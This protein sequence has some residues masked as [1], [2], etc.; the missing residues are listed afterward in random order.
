MK[1]ITLLFLA[2]FFLF[3]QTRIAIVG[4]GMAGVSALYHLQEYDKEAKITLFEKEAVLGGNATTVAIK[5]TKGEICTVDAGP[6]Y[7]A[8][9][10]WEDYLDFIEK[11]IGKEEIKYE[12]VGG[13][14]VIRQVYE[15]NAIIATPLNGK[16][17]GEKLG[18][19]LKF[20]KLNEEAHRLYKEA[21][22]HSGL[23]IE[24]WV[25]SLNFDEDYKQQIVYPFLGSS[26][27]VSVHDIRKMSAVDIV[28]LF[29]FRKPK[30]SDK[31]HIMQ[32]GMGTII[33]KI[34]ASVKNPNV[35]IHTSALVHDVLLKENTYLVTY[36]KNGKSVTEEF[37]F[38][39]M[40]VH[41]NTAAK[42]L[43]SDLAFKSISNTL[44]TFPYFEAKIVIH[45]DD[46]FV[47]HKKPA[48]LNIFTD[49]E[50][51][52]VSSTM[53]LDL[54]SPRLKGIYKSWMNTED[55]EK[56]RKQ[57]KLLYETVFYHPMITVEFVENLKIL[58]HQIDNFAPN[59]CIIGGWSEGLE[60]QNS[61]VLSGK[62][63]L[64][65]YKRFKQQH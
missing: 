54:I 64:E 45:S 27:G 40:A 26:L 42:I 17:R 20:K 10:A 7:F 13:S 62:R 15:E 52:I 43:A 3:A 46:S 9:Q 14:L 32:E 36:H 22:K 16:M 30:M 38:V 65:I 61:A 34:G 18:N 31:F 60:T 50:H 1:S 35:T 44:K 24:A 29:A 23:T 57:N 12:S 55:A 8:D 11:T 53:N 6:Q 25:A 49:K 41:A 39:I 28:K 37:D 5:N 59:F 21:D 63:A 47:H 58:H 51:N 4:G 48:F 56:V 33:Q 19:L 2:P